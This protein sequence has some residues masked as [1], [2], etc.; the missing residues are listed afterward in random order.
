MQLLRALLAQLLGG[1]LVLL[2]LRLWPGLLH[3]AWQWAG[4]QGLL[5]AGC[6]LWLRQPRWW[7]P[8]HL[9]FV[10]AVLAASLL[11]WPAEVYLAG[12]ALMLLLFWGV[13]RGD[14]PL[15]LSS[16][17]VA[18]ALAA[19]A[20]REQA[21]TFAELGA[22]TGSVAIPMARRLPRLQVTAWEN[23][24]LPWAILAWR[25]RRLGNLALRRGSLW[26]ADLSGCALAF[27]FLSPAPMAQLGIKLQD[28]MP[29]GSLF[30][31]S[32]FPVPEWPPESVVELDDRR[33][34]RLYCY[35]IAER[36]YG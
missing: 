5:A 12:F 35:R 32:S 36:K 3:G 13:V 17:A 11:H 4:L 8:M 22:G 25:G 14:A 19:I 10:P 7:L 15:F 31:S 26:Q 27:A 29:A 20:Q 6:S 1:M 30:V 23:A 2:C 21:A 18:D 24:P 34:T 28:E 9:L 33:G 16:R